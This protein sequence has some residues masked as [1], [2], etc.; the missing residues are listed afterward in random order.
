MSDEIP[1]FQWVGAYSKNLHFGCIYG[2]SN[3][4]GPTK[5]MYQHMISGMFVVKVLG[6]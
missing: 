5:E 2:V 4:G 1:L 6:K 3:T